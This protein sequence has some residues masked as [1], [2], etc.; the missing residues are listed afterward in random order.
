MSSKTRVQFFS[1]LESHSMADASLTDLHLA[2]VCPTLAFMLLRCVP[3]KGI[4]IF[5][6]SWT[7]L[8]LNY[9]FWWRWIDGVSQ[10]WSLNL[11]LPA[12]QALFIDEFLAEN[13]SS[14]IFWVTDI[15]DKLLVPGSG[16]R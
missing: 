16:H 13:M 4:D 14:R 11:I 8:A 7:V 3:T 15:L 2:Q 5:E 10:G 6:F 1:K 12:D 9:L